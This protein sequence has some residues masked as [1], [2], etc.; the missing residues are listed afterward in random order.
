[1]PVLI[2][3]TGEINGLSAPITFDSTAESSETIEYDGKQ[4]LRTTFE[5]AIEFVMGLEKRENTALGPHPDPVEST[6]DP[7]IT[8]Y[9]YGVEQWQ[10][11]KM[12]WIKQPLVG[13]SSQWVKSEKF[14]RWT[15]DG[16]QLRLLEACLGQEYSTHASFEAGVEGLATHT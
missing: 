2:V 1:M 5:T 8:N 10:A 9:L 14:P 15:G 4:A 6:A 7:K 3:L 13:P 12:G 11:R 16:A